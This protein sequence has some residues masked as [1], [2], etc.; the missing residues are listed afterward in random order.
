MP[1]SP[2]FNL[3]IPSLDDPS[4]APEGRHAASSFAFYLPIG[5]DREAQGRL[6]DEMAQRIVARIAS[7]APNFPD[8]IERQLNYPP[9]PTS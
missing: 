5:A 9:T 6:R 8:I 2:R 4:L 1:H 7:A 3:Q